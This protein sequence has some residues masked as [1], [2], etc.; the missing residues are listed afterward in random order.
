[1]GLSLVASAED[2]KTAAEPQATAQT[3]PA[4][5][6]GN[7]VSYAPTAGIWRDQLIAAR[8]RVV[9]AT[10]ALDE[11]NADYAKALY[12]HPD[13]E[14]LAAPLAKKRAEAGNRLAEAKAEIPPLVA[15][16]RADGTSERVLKLYEQSID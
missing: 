8:K 1:M 14:K 9:A 12:E 5:P 11:A 10:A 6:A 7:P 13:D 16:A 3:A 15:K 2:E 4:K